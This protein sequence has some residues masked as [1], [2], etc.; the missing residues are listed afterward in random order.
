MKPAAFWGIGIQ[1][2]VL[3]LLM[4]LTA[5]CLVPEYRVGRDNSL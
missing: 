1:M 2:A 4:V 5:G 3:C